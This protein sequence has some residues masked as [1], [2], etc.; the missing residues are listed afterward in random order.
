MTVTGEAPLVN[1]EN[2]TLG[3]LMNEQQM[4]DLPLNGRNY[5]DFSLMQPGVTEDRNNGGYQGDSTQYGANGAPVRS[6][7][8]RS[9]ALRLPR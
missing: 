1:T 2:S 7:N 9:M 6:N 8:L 4:S 3:G 5:M